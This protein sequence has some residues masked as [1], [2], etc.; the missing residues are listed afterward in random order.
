MTNHNA[1]ILTIYNAQKLDVQH[2]FGLSVYYSLIDICAMDFMLFIHNSVRVTV[3]SNKSMFL[4]GNCLFY[5]YD[6]QYS[7]CKLAIFYI[8]AMCSP[9]LKLCCCSHIYNH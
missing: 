9:F 2:Y 1:N 8:I 6:T 5:I 7:S 4:C 3:G